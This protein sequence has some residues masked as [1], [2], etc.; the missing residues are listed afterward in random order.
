MACSFPHT[1]DEIK[2]LVQKQIDEDTICKEAIFDVT[3]LFEQA[4]ADKEDPRE[5]YAKCKDV[6]QEKSVVIDKFLEDEDRKDYEIHSAL[7]K[8]VREIQDNIS[9]K[10]RWTHKENK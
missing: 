7:F 8:L 6:P 4:R 1:I 3:K 10:V 5:A 2:A 9:H